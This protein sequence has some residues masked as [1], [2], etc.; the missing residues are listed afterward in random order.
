MR[1]NPMS[2][3]RPSLALDR[4]RAGMSQQKALLPPGEQQV[5]QRRGVVIAVDV[6]ALDRVEHREFVGG[7]RDRQVADYDRRVGKFRSVG[8]VAP[9]WPV[10]LDDGVPEILRRPL[11]RENRRL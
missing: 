3:W 8:R 4:G 7:E 2:F 6:G 5:A 10:G 9:Q 11:A 1:L